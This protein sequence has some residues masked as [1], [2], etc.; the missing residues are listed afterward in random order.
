MF[1]LWSAE[2]GILFT[3]TLFA[4]YGLFVSSHVIFPSVS[5]CDVIVSSRHGNSK[6]GTFH[7]PKSKITGNYPSNSHCI[8]KFIG[9]ATERVKI[10]F[11]KFE[12]QGRA[13]A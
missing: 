5:D 1:D 8:Y 10:R 4:L 12:L 11:T 7:S 13:P 3:Q 2:M 6:N 9:W